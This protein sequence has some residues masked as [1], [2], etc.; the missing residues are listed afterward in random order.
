MDIVEIEESKA[1]ICKLVT[2]VFLVVL[3]FTY[4]LFVIGCMV[5]MA[6]IEERMD[7]RIQNATM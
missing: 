3:F 7:Q 2:T 4:F 1:E 5:V 6:A